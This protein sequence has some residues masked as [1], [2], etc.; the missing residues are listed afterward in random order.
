[1]F[2]YALKQLQK[3]QV[4]QYQQQENVVTEKNVMAQ[5]EHPFILKLVAT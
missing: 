3:A 1:V 2:S 4:V 5:C